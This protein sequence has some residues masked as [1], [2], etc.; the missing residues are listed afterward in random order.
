MSDGKWSGRSVKRA[1]GFNSSALAS[2]PV[3][4]TIRVRKKKGR[5]QGERE[6]ESREQR[7]MKIRQ[8]QRLEEVTK[9][10]SVFAIM[11]LK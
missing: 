7:G 6:E 4:Q 9:N 10:R 1:R 5:E 8:E 2:D 3:T 11:H